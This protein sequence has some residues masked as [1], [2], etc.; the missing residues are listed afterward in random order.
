[1]E[2]INEEMNA[3]AKSSPN[4]S[5]HKLKQAQTP[6]SKNIVSGQR[7]VSKRSKADTEEE[8]EMPRTTSGQIVLDASGDRDKG[9]RISR[10][11]DGPLG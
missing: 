5:G 6:E 9:E 2:I 8:A 10:N 1:M 4:K 11:K 3:S 7:S